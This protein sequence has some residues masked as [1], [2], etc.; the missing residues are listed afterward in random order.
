M[1][2]VWF[3]L[4]QSESL[5]INMLH[6]CTVPP[7]GKS[8][9]PR[10][11]QTAAHYFRFTLYLCSTHK[12]DSSQCDLKIL[13]RVHGCFWHHELQFRSKI[14]C[15][16]SFPSAVC[17]MRVNLKCKFHILQ[18]F[19]LTYSFIKDLLLIKKQKW[20]AL[21]HACLFSHLLLHK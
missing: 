6:E 5:E 17:M 7:I 13:E 18:Y 15:I 8:L 16:K 20:N 11:I 14:L 2:Y 9:A 19:L 3:S 12:W 21:L 4:V 1:I 10:W